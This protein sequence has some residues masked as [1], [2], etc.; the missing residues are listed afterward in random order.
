MAATSRIEAH[1]RGLFDPSH[2]DPYPDEWGFTWVGDRSVERVGYATNLT[3]EVAHEAVAQDVD[4]VLTHHDAWSFVFGM[5]EA[6]AEVLHPRGISHCFFHA[7]LDAADFGTGAAL[8]ESLGL[9]VTGRCTL[10]R[11]V[12]LCGR[13][14][15][16]EQAT[17]LG[18]LAASLEA[19]LGEPVR[20][21][22]HNDAPVRR[23]CVVTGGG[24]TTDLLKEAVDLGCDTYITGAKMLYTVEYARLASLN[25]LVGSHTGTELPGTE[26]LARRVAQACAIQAVRLAE[27]QVE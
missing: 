22:R 27:P 13:V 16:P 26:A 18:A 17:G 12:F 15:E 25:L 9:R 20:A 6:C 7:P 4:L 2:L 3:P 24:H 14:G 21:W 5:A 23:A 11:D 19:I 1:I 8:A 10:Y